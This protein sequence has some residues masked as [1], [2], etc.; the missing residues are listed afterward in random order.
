MRLTVIY[1][2]KFIS[3]DGKG[4]QFTDNWPFEETHIHAIQWHDENGELELRTREPNIELTDVSEVQKYADFFVSEYEKL[5][6]EEA[7]AAEEKEKLE[8]AMRELE[9]NINMFNN[10]SNLFDEEALGALKSSIETFNEGSDLFGENVEFFKSN[11][12]ETDLSLLKGLEQNINAF[13]NS[14]QNYQSNLNTYFD[15]SDSDSSL[16]D[17]DVPEQ[18][19]NISEDIQ[20]IFEEQFS[21][22]EIDSAYKFNEDDD[23]EEIG[24]GENENEEGSDEENGEDDQFDM[25]LLE[26]DFNIEMLQEQLDPDI[27]E[28]EDLIKNISDSGLLEE[29]YELDEIKENTDTENVL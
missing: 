22:E 17:D 3:V 24:D 12:S 20:E 29:D 5:K 26:D 10:T 13:N 4:L 11:V 7:R 9:M 25:S 27:N 21:L 1:D 14:L 23:E 15:P 2:D 18:M 16:F 19:F 28:M 8:M 6:A